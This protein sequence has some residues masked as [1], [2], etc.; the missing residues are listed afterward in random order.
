MKTSDTIDGKCPA[1]GGPVSKDLADRGFVRHTEE[2][3][4]HGLTER[5]VSERYQ[6]KNT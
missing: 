3:C 2:S 5:D 4:G 1:C 6:E